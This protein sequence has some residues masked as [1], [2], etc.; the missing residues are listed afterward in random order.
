MDGGL[1]GQDSHCWTENIEKQ[2][3]KARVNEVVL[4]KSRRHWYELTFSLI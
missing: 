3:G 2:E 1:W 4:E